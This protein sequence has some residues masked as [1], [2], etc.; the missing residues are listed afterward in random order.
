[1]RQIFGAAITARPDVRPDV[2]GP[3]QLAGPA[4]RPR[5]GLVLVPRPP[6]DAEAVSEHR[7][8]LLRHAR[9]LMGNESDAQDLVHDT[10]ERALRAIDQFEPGTN[11]RAWLYTIMVRRARD[12]FRARRGR[13]LVP[14][15]LEDLP[16]P[17]SSEDPPA[18]W[19]AVSDEQLRAA[20]ERLPESFRQV[21]ELHAFGRLAY[22]DIAA[23][24]DVP[25]ATVGTRLKRARDRLRDLLERD[26]AQGGSA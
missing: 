16:A 21:F 12:Q 23:R 4:L 17:D 20:L 26:L 13:E 24:L 18:P 25:V 11:L 9:R 22:A 5:P 3:A 8:D 6:S 2:A 14:M 10:V 15:A 19:R 7:P 1:M